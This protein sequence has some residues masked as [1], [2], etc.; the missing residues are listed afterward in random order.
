MDDASSSGTK[1]V[2]VTV[3]V[4]EGSV[5]GV[6]VQDWGEILKEA[7]KA[8]DEML[9]FT[10]E[11]IQA[12]P[13][14]TAENAFHWIEFLEKISVSAVSLRG[15][16]YRTQAQGVRIEKGTL[17][18]VHP[19]FLP[20]AALNSESGEIQGYQVYIGD[21]PDSFLME[22]P[23]DP[24]FPWVRI[25]YPSISLGWE[26]GP[27]EEGEVLG[28]YESLEEA[29]ELLRSHAIRALRQAFLRKHLEVEREMTQTEEGE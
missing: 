21:Q 12:L 20:I 18:G 16:F 29:E 13:R 3:S 4:V 8:W 1:Q 7:S 23:S 25:S 10:S 24:E 11:Q 5:D 27:D 22:A 15:Q 26:V 28:G 14:L 6:K 9:R 2:T 17:V 19:R